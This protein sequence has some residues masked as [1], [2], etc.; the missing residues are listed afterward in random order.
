MI[1]PWRA[2]INM[3]QMTWTTDCSIGLMGFS[4]GGRMNEWWLLLITKGI[5]VQIPPELYPTDRAASR[6]A[7]RWA[8]VFRP[9][10]HDAPVEF[11]RQMLLGQGITLHIIKPPFEEPWRSCPLWVGVQSSEA[12]DGLKIKTHLG[13]MSDSEAKQWLVRRTNQPLGM[14]LRDESFREAIYVNGRGV[15]TYAGIHR[16]KRLFAP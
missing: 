11:R 1:D 2:A 9:E 5:R 6:E 15:R 14:S 3:C 4:Q 10:L 16:V 13:P 8:A 12:R 7:R